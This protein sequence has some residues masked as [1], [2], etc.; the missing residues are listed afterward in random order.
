MKDLSQVLADT[1]TGAVRDFDPEAINFLWELAQKQKF[2]DFLVLSGYRTPETNRIVH[3][4]GDSQHLR[5]AALDIHIPANKYA[6][7][8]EAA[9]GMGRGGVGL[10]SDQGFIHLDAGPVRHWG[11]APGTAV[12][13]A[14]AKPAP[15]PDPLAK[16]ADAWA[17]TRRR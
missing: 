6:S 16:M 3:G 5:A 13:A 4:A 17:A 14:R 2:T 11:T 1:R 10:Y 9:L 15:K 8:S 12:A 7:F